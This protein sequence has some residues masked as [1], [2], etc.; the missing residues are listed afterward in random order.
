[1]AV[2]EKGTRF[3]EKIN[4]DEEN[5][6]AVFRVSAHNNV[7]VADFYHDFNLVNFCTLSWDMTDMENWREFAGETL[8]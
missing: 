7:N 3:L 6:V 4:F 8:K 1:M 2:E 5:N